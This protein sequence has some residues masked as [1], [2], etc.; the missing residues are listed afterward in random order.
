MRKII[1]KDILEPAQDHLG[2]QGDVWFGENE[3]TLRFGDGTTNGGVLGYP[4]RLASGENSATM[5]A[6]GSITVPGT[7]K[8]TSSLHLK[9]E[10]HTHTNWV[11]MVDNG[12]DSPIYAD[13]VAY[14]SQGNVILGGNYEFNGFHV[15]KMTSTGDL[16]WSKFLDSL[17]S[18][19]TGLTVDAEDN[20]VTLGYWDGVVVVIKLN[21]TNG[22]T[23]W[24][25]EITDVQFTELTSFTVKTD[26]DKNIAICGWIDIG[27][28]D[29]FSVFKMAGTTGA[30]L[31]S[32]KLDFDISTSVST[33]L[34]IDP[35]GDIFVAGNSFGEHPSWINAVKI[36]GRTGGLIWNKVIYDPTDLLGPTTPADFAC[37]GADADQDGNFFLSMTW[38]N[39]DPLSVTIVGKW[40]KDG[41]L[42]WARKLGPST[43]SAIAGHT[44]CDASGNVYSMSQIT[45]SENNYLDYGDVFPG[46][47]HE[48]RLVYLIAKFDTNGKTAWTRYLTKRQ[49][50]VFLNSYQWFFG[51]S[52]S[53]KM[54]DVR[55]ENLALCGTL[56][57]NDPYSTSDANST[58]P[59]TWVMQIP[60]DGAPF[61]FNGWH[62]YA[63]DWTIEWI[64]VPT[65][66]EVGS[67]TITDAP[68][69]SEN[70]NPINAINYD[71]NH[72]SKELLVQTTGQ[73]VTVDSSGIKI[74]RETLGRFITLGNFDG[75]E[76]GNDW[77][78]VWFNGVARDANGNSYLPTGIDTTRY[79]SYLT[80]VNPEGKVAWQAAMP[81][82]ITFTAAAVAIDPTTQ[83][84]VFVSLD[85][86]EGFNITRMDASGGTTKSN[87]RVLKDINDGS[88]YEPYDVKVDNNG[89]PV[90]VGRNNYGYT[91]YPNL[92]AG[93]ATSGPD[94]LIVAKSVFPTD[95][96]PDSNGSW[97]VVVG[98]TRYNVDD[99]NNWYNL[100]ST[101]NSTNGGTS[102]TWD[103]Y[104]DPDTDQYNLSLGNSGGSLYQVGDE[105]YISGALVLGDAVVNKI[106][107]TVNSVDGGG[108]ILTWTFTSG[109]P[110]TE[111]VKINTDTGGALNF[112]VGG[113]FIVQQYTGTDGFVW[114]PDWG[115]SLGDN[116]NT[117]TDY[118]LSVAVGSDNSVVAGGEYNS[119]ASD[120]TGIVCKFAED[121]TPLWNVLVDNNDN[122]HTVRGV[123]ID[124][125]GNVLAFSTAYDGTSYV[126]KLDGQDGS[127]MWQVYVGDGDWSTDPESGF[128]VD[129]EGFCYMGGRYYEDNWCYND[130][131]L[132]VKIDPDG[133]LVYM[134]DIASN[135]DVR[136]GYDYEQLNTLS[137]KNG[138]MSIAIDYSDTPG[139]DYYQATVAD[140]PNDGSGTGN[141]GPWLYREIEYPYERYSNNSTDAN[142]QLAEHVFYLDTP[143]LPPA[144]YYGMQDQITGEIKATT[145]GDASVAS[146]TFEDGTTMSTSGQD[147]PQVV[148]SRTSW[149]DYLVQ[150]EDRGKHIYKWEGNVIIPT[151]ASVPFPIGSTITIVTDEFTVYLYPDDNNTTRIRGIG[152]DDSGS[153]YYIDP[154][155]MVTLLKV[156]TD[157]WMLSGGTFGTN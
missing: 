147:V 24:A 40:D 26:K 76:G 2:Q 46:D 90:V 86:S 142:A 130:N 70:T 95:A 53:G 136:E 133:N 121:G 84:P 56:L 140:L 48:D 28:K 122:Y 144:Q 100:A 17:D 22:N 104:I 50:M 102:S 126:A 110:Q 89:R 132:I 20:I 101:T 151:N 81:D 127:M 14:D 145:G 66:D 98:A 16:L 131:Y 118:F 109:V 111:Y 18:I 47:Y 63:T 134:R 123:R 59:L 6:D 54:I 7:I 88:C 106:T 62:F 45:Q 73:T 10:S 117:S 129:N 107:I 112:S 39:N 113:P 82:F 103:V 61:D 23:V 137:V 3:N 124:S 57:R 120:K 43:N 79:Y 152:A 138:R 52:T 75:A 4:D 44:V 135:Y 153:S 77:N 13:S 38:N 15:S 141:Y 105:I 64:T 108:S 30:T 67:W 41:T 78:N 51:Y 116:F 157:T 36:E 114:T 32:K 148:Q 49:Y 68:L 83:D 60:T 31:W 94:T 99:V 65:F 58:Y 92:P 55:G 42:K 11:G 119:S 19:S 72:Y 96:Y 9:G 128:D 71:Y 154:Y 97:Y 33:T 25:K 8:S 80:K 29:V 85:G 27:A 21:G 155:S 93:V 143:S 149:A 146:I 34:A 5:A 150:L 35:T 91:Q 115:R 1:T 12:E 125:K 87:T 37:G 139:N 74:E 69:S 156:R